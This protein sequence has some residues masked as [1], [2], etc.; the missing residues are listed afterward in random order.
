MSLRKISKSFYRSGFRG[1]IRGQFTVLRPQPGKVKL[2]VTTAEVELLV[3]QPEVKTKAL[4][5][6]MTTA[7][8]YSE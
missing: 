1:W 5:P 2:K 8:I 6:V 7:I 4:T 3:M